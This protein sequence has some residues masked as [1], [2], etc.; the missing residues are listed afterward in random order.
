MKKLIELT[1]RTMI[2]FSTI[3]ISIMPNAF[4]L[5]INMC[6]NKRFLEESKKNRSTLRRR[7][8]FL[9]NNAIQMNSK[10]KKSS[11]QCNK[12]YNF[13]SR[14]SSIRPLS[15]SLNTRRD[16]G[17]LSK[18]NFQTSSIK[19]KRG[20]DNFSIRSRTHSIG[21]MIGKSHYSLTK[22]RSSVRIEKHGYTYIR[23]ISRTG[24][25]K[26]TITKHSKKCVDKHRRLTDENFKG[27]KNFF[28]ILKRHTVF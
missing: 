18:P 2:I 7:S 22:N 1:D 8:A 4:N 5:I 9:L 24:K 11:F 16:T 27:K 26:Y 12:N 23:Q 20:G 19:T 21:T 14:C 15:I 17:N 6:L 3:L 25:A 28:M 13:N 10:F